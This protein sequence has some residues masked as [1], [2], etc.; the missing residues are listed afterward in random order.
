MI[1]IRF[2]KCFVFLS[3]IFLLVFVFTFSSM[4]EE[5]IKSSSEIQDKLSNI[6]NEEKKVLEKM[7]AL[8]QEIED[9]DKTESEIVNDIDA[10]KKEIEKL[11]RLITNEEI[12]Y[13]KNRDALKNILKTYQKNGPAS[14]IE[15]ILDSDSLKTAMQRLNILR[16]ITS[17]TAKLLEDTESNKTKL[18]KQRLSVDEKLALIKDKQKKSQ[19]ILGE[20]VKLKKDLENYLV[21]LQEER[22]HYQGYLMDFKQIWKETKTILPEIIKTFSQIIEKNNLPNDTIKITF[23]SFEIKGILEEQILNKIVSDYPL[24][25]KISFKFELDKVKME[26]P[27]KNIV[28]WGKFV[29]VDGQALKFEVDK[30]TFYGMIVDD[31]ALEELFSEGYLVLD[32]KPMLGRSVLKSIDIYEKYIELRITYAL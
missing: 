13:E 4:G 12:E 16:D 10:T 18:T 6:S 15:I 2:W 24:L 14:Y 3:L 23:S 26:I 11:E 30:V 22:V 5:Y 25:S 20:K 17:N 9:M 27:E 32:L 7:V 28:L 1:K 29:I 31:S 19:E 21:S 8:S